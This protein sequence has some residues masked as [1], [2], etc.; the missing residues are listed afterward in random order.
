[1]CVQNRL[2]SV[3]FRQCFLFPK[4]FIIEVFLRLAI[5][6]AFHTP[7]HHENQAKW[8]IWS[9][10]IGT[11]GL[12]SLIRSLAP[13][14]C[15]C[16]I[17]W[18]IISNSLDERTQN[19]FIV[20]RAHVVVA[21]VTGALFSPHYVLDWLDLILPILWFNYFEPVIILYKEVVMN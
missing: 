6:Y 17:Y 8:F 21:D 7:I 16:I 1:M 15:V 19:M 10:E 11:I 9:R 18:S 3:L 13:C 2:Q 5:T 20:E 4:E 14:W 12:F